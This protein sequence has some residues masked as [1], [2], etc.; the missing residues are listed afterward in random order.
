MTITV[1]DDDLRLADSICGGD[2]AFAECFA[3]AQIRRDEKVHYDT[4]VPP[5]DTPMRRIAMAFAY[6][7]HG[8]W[9]NELCAQCL[10]LRVITRAFTA[11]AARQTACPGMMSLQAM[12]DEDSPFQHTALLAKGLLHV[13]EYICR[14]SIDGQHA[15]TGLLV[16]PDMVMT[17]GHVFDGI[18]SQGRPLIQG[19]AVEPDSWKRIEVFFGDRI[20]IL[21]GLRARL[22]PRPFKVVEN[23]LLAH[24][25][26]K[27]NAFGVAAVDIKKPDF[28]LIRL[29]GSPNPYAR[30][31]PMERSAPYQQDPLLIIQHPS[32]NPLCHQDGLVGR[33]FPAAN[34]FLHSVNSLPGSSGAPCFNTNFEVVGIHTGEALGVTPRC[35]V[36]VGI[37]HPADAVD[38]WTSEATYTHPS[39]FRCAEGLTNAI[40]QR[41]TTL[42]WLKDATTGDAARILAISPATRRQVGMSFTAEVIAGLLPKDQHR[43]VKLSTGQFHSRT[44]LDFAQLLLE[45]CG[46]A[47]SA[48]LPVANG[49]TTAVAYLRNDLVPALI[50]KLDTIRGER[51][52]WLILD[53]LRRPDETHV[54]LSE[55]TGLRE[56][57]DLIYQAVAGYEWLRIV[58]LGYDSV[59]PDNLKNYWTNE[60]LTE[61]TPAAFADYL[62]A[63]IDRVPDQSDR[64][65]YNKM[66]IASREQLEYTPQEKQLK[67]AANNARLF[68]KMLGVTA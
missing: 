68:L 56:C 62:Q 23:W 47:A 34:I 20:D 4:I 54:P 22:T 63:L 39:F 32:G 44:P 3:A 64:D 8:G 24:N 6:A 53:D 21:H 36:A 1:S 18:H 66:L 38:Q 27:G 10:E 61:V 12:L 35:N 41:E 11:Q 51:M 29:A 42:D 50:D 9:L 7:R 28:A 31:L 55:G 58:L 52:F 15:G 13:T 17:A 57:L 26:P 43:V 40:V 16:P 30:P 14:I 60:T 25:A 46:A 2:S 45:K 65:E 49:E 5:N 37:L 33:P 48:D 59:I 67:N 19:G